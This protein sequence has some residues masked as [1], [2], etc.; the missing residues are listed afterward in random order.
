MEIDAY[1]QRAFGQGET[2]K[3]KYFMKLDDLDFLY[4]SIDD[5]AKRIREI[6]LVAPNMIHQFNLIHCIKLMIVYVILE[7]IIGATQFIKLLL[8]NTNDYG[9]L[10]DVVDPPYK[11][12]H[13][14]DNY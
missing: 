1:E 2:E 14:E 4:N 10:I 11:F 6:A 13:S 5:D 12:A 8:N 9:P 3:M 7:Y